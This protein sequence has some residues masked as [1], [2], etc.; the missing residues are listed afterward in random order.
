MVR[1]FVNKYGKWIVSAVIVLALALW[2]ILSNNTENYAH[3]YEGVD[4]SV[5][6]EGIGR[7]NT[8]ELYLS[9]SIIPADISAAELT[10]EAAYHTS[11]A[12]TEAGVVLTA[13]ELPE[14]ASATTLENGTPF[15]RYSNVLVAENGAGA[16]FKVS[17]PTAGLYTITFS[18]SELSE[19]Q[20]D[21]TSMLL[22]G[23]TPVVETSSSAADT[24][25]AL[26]RLNAGENTVAVSFT[27][28]TVI[29]TLN[30]QGPVRSNAAE[31]VTVDLAGVEA[32]EGVAYHTAGSITSKGYF[33]PGENAQPSDAEKQGEVILQVKN[34]VQTDS[35]SSA[36]WKVNVPASGYYNVQ[37]TYLTTLSRGVDLERELLINGELPF[38]GANKMTFSR[39]WTDGPKPE[40]DTQGNER[41]P[42]Q[43]EVFG[44]EQ[45]AW[46]RDS[47]GYVTEPY[48]FYFEAGENT[49]TLNATSE[50]M[51]LTGIALKAPTQRQSYEDY[52]AA[53][54]DKPQPEGLKSLAPIEGE[55]SVRRSSPSLYAKYDRSSPAT[56]PYDV[57]HTVLNYTGGD[58]WRD[59]GQWIEWDFTVDQAGW[60]NIT[61]KGRQTYSRGSVSSRIVYLDDQILFDGMENV[62]FAYS[63]NWNM[64]TLSDAEGNA[65]RFYLTEGSHRI[66]MEAT[67]GDMGPILSDMEESVY[68]LNSMYRKILVLT[69]VTPDQYRDYH[70]EQKYPEVIAEM[71][72]ES[73]RL[74]KLLDDTVALT[75]QKS[76]RIASVQTLALQLETFVDDPAEITQAFTNFK[77]NITSIGTSMLNLR[78]V[79]LD[80]DQIYI[81]ADGEKPAQ[82]NEGFLAKAWHE[83]VSCFTSYTVDY[84]AL[85]N[86]YEGDD[87]LE[88]WIVTGRDQSNVLKAMVDD[89]FTSLTGIPVNVMLVDPN[90]LLNAT[91][92]GN[93]PDVVVS[94]DSWNP[95]NYALRGA[96]EDLTQFNAEFVQK[97]IIDKYGI[98]T[99]K[100]S[101]KP[102]DEVMTQFY[103]SAYQAF[104]FIDETGHEGVYALP[105][106]QLCSIMFYRSDILE[107]YGLEVPRTWDALIA[108]LPT[109]QGANM[110]V[111]IPYPDIV[112]PNLSSF[113]SMIYQR[114]G[115]IYNEDAT[116][117]TLNEEAA[118]AAFDMYTSLY[119]DYGLPL[120]FDFVSRFRSGEMP[121]GIFDYTTFN[122]LNVS[123]PEIRGLWEIAVMPGTAKTDENGQP[124]LDENG[125][126]VIDHA[127]HTQGACCMMIATDDEAIKA[128]AW[129]FMQWWVST[130][131]QVRFGREIEAILGS[132]A[133]YATANIAA[134]EQLAW[135]EDQLDVIREQMKVAIGFREVAG[136]YYTTRHI[137]NAVRKVTNEKTD[138]R[139]TLLDY[140][141]T[142]NEEIVKKREEFGLPVPEEAIEA[143]RNA[144]PT[145]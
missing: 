6:T 120:I 62:D 40:N 86:V 73:K 108:M 47:M 103:P 57:A 50:P 10:G 90:A 55:A 51:L 144:T 115:S 69:G 125:E 141:R 41:R 142:I 84:S 60:Y 65:Y 98:D 20:L 58:A 93:G 23:S 89:T 127:G 121:I 29:D 2:F 26:Y 133:R 64:N 99:T 45:S 39:I 68:R 94:T 139:E 13:E 91:V 72:K 56:V 100:V 35:D 79:Q 36:S 81:T 53:I 12:V 105:E 30:V 14:D 43:V 122:T 116:M 22:N 126:P 106:T 137:T 104:K 124:L 130:D 143:T 59:A 24:H 75:G 52:L 129:A 38:D 102:Y 19:T 17:V 119:N 88:V 101:V 76:D 136:G 66:R 117:T 80:V 46:C 27:G 25:A 21:L 107:E 18:Y 92:A 110:S 15:E 7:D 145:N 95:V 113:Y 4:L 34:V 135:S 16:A 5:S 54:G 74:F 83:I 138:P 112:A 44:R 87:V 78:Q 49:I 140:A 28:H 63:S 33:L 3:K 67:L 123:A 11:L 114:G 71:D 111:G 77:D 132:S 128:Q 109:L 42:Q 37:L 9:G 70:L 131:A 96:A 1:S 85:G 82:P 61:I 48:L 118:V 31:D 134:I 97:N 32:G 8:Y